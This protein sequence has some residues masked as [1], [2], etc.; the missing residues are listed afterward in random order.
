[1][2]LNYKTIPFFLLSISCVFLFMVLT[3][4]VNNVPKDKFLLFSSCMFISSLVAW[5]I[6]ERIDNQD[7][8]ERS[9]GVYFPQIHDREIQE[10]L[11]E[12][13]WAHIGLLV[14]L[15]FIAFGIVLF[16]I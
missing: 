13:N 5:L 16:N 7:K 4:N 2:E 15:V 6:D 3:D 11:N 10:K 8:L 12:K 9:S 14:V 1:M